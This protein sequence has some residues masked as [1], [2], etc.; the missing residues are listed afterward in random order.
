MSFI[1]DEYAIYL[2]A[3]NAQYAETIVKPIPDNRPFP[4]ALTLDD[5]VFW[6]ANNKFWHHPHFLHSIITITI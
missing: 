2:P 1:S 5:L 4:D 3:V 6:Q